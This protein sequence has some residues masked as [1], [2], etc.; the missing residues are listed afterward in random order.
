MKFLEQYYD[1]KTPEQFTIS[2]DQGSGFAKQ[3]AGDFNPIHH[4]DAKRFCVPGDLLFAIALQ[5]YGLNQK[6]AFQFTNIVSA[7][8]TLNYPEAQEGGDVDLTVTCDR[9]KAVL[10][11]QFSGDQCRNEQRIEPILRSYVQFSGQNFPHI[12]V[13]LMEQENAMINPTR[14]LVMYQ[15]MA[16]ELQSMDFDLLDIELTNSSLK[17]E[18][19]RG[20]VTL[21]FAFMSNGHQ[22]GTGTKNLVLGGLREYDETGIQQ[23]VDEYE[24]SKGI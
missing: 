4:P 9:D 12:L 14:P 7:G 18:G 8:A 15:S 11:V 5:R 16:F 24:A 19:K 22:V 2:A 6:M 10:A 17:S 13:P 1:Q 23:M 21:D 20:D 3:V